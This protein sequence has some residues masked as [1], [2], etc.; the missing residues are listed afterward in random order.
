M[1]I[2]SATSRGCLLVGCIV[3]LFVRSKLVQANPRLL[4]I[5]IPVA[6]AGY[7]VLGSVF[8]LSGMAAQ[9][10]GRDPTLTGRTGT[11][12]VLLQLQDSPLIG[13]GY[14]SLWTGDRIARILTTLG[15]SYLNESH[16]GYLE[17]YMTLGLVGLALCVVFLLSGFRKICRQITVSPDYAAFGLAI[18]VVTVMYNATETAIGGGLLWSVLLYFTIVVHRREPSLGTEYQFGRS[19]GAA[20]QPGILTRPA[21]ISEKTPG[22]LSRS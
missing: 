14:S 18:W 5:G 21:A 1:F 4:T 20:R 10:L 15:V 17:I 12:K 9:L 8:D 16:N 11:W 22:V 19:A 3:V 6:I 2:D 7:F 13:L